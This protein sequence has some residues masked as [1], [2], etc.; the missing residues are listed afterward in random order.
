MS[1]ALRAPMTLTAFLDWEGRQP[2]RYEFDGFQPVAMTG[3][4]AEHAA[5]QIN[6]TTAL[7]NR[8]RGGTCRAFGSELK[9]LVAGSVRYPDAFVVCT[10]IP[11]GTHVVT[12]PVVVFEVLSPSTSAIDRIDKLREYLDTPS[13][14]RYVIL[15][16]SRIAA[17]VHSRKGE[18]R[19][20]N[21]LVGP[22]AVLAMPEIGVTVPLSELY[23][24]VTFAEA[25]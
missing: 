15:E 4:S 24:D 20:V 11:P 3:G 13:V 12:E 18:E 16:Q 17:T 5:I 23:E 14:Q 19:V 7:R 25:G 21:I 6:L 8:L 1:M 9:I 2:V 22:E 10:P